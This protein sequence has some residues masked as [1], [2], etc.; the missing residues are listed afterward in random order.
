MCMNTT[1]AQLYMLDHIKHSLATDERTH[2][3]DVE[4]QMQRNAVTLLGTVNCETRRTMIEQVVREVVP[5]AVT[6]INQLRVVSYL[7]PASVETVGDPDRS[8]W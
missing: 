5:A 2:V 6:I 4:V 8:D 3:A 1:P 7:E